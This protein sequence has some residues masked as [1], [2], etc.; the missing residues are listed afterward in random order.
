MGDAQLTG[1][2]FSSFHFQQWISAHGYWGIFFLLMLGIFGLP[3]PDEPLLV[4]SGYLISR[5][6]LHPAGVFLASFCGSAVGISVSYLLGRQLGLRVISHYG[7]L[8]GLSQEKLDRVHS[9][10]R[11]MGHWVLVFGYFMPGV[12]HITALVAGISSLELAPFILFAY[13]G[14]LLWVSTFLSVGYFFADDWDRISEAIHDNLIVALC[15][16]AAAGL[17]Y[18]FA[19]RLM[20]R[21]RRA[22]N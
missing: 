16:V 19:R 17:A 2:V 21:R 9:W 10:F 11:G 14:A 12:R 4:L 1:A 22:L 3:I 20:N 13:S 6:K 18:V 5:G 8:V 7:N 15:I